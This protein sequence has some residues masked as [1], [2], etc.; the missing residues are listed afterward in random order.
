ML[1]I[2]GRFKIE[3]QPPKLRKEPHYRGWEVQAFS[4]S[5]IKFFEAIGEVHRGISNLGFFRKILQG[6]ALS[7]TMAVGYFFKCNGFCGLR[8]RFKS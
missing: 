4:G 8:K 3:V 2:K 6:V 5:H 1:V 7:K